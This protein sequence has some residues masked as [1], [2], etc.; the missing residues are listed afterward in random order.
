MVH[1]LYFHVPFCHRICPYCGFYK[2]QPGATSFRAFLDGVILEL[3]AAAKRNPI[4]ARTIYFGGGTPSIF[5]AD[6]WK[7]FAARLADTI[8]LAHVTE[9]TL[10]ANPRT[11]DE[12]KVHAWRETGVTRISLGVQSFHPKI[13]SVL[14]RDHSPDEAAQ[15]V[16]DLRQAA[17]PVVNIDL[18]FAIPGQNLE[19]W[20][21]TLQ[22]AIELQP[23][24]VSAYNLTYEE[25][26]EFLSRF[27][28][29]EWG[30][31]ADRDA[32]F[33]LLA[34][35][36]LGDAGF[37]H[38][39]VSNYAR[40]GFRSLH[41]QAYWAGAEYLGLGPS[42]VSTIGNERRKNLADTDG[43]LKMVAGLGHA[44]HEIEALDAGQQALER[45]ALGLRTEGGIDLAR[46]SA[47]GAGRLVEEGL[48]SREGNRLCL[49]LEG[50]MVA[51]EI[52][53]FL[54]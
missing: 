39:E 50:M 6:L 28:S 48:A 38:Y 46:V 49:T 37:A 12:A 30:Q 14:G 31:D 54:S 33:F 45:L 21:E 9:W 26:T 29:G 17:M 8:D 23:D 51:D 1:H 25:D 35:R 16:R 2:H 34:D 42:A 43:Y 52:A 19:I 40:P 20:G 3:A 10:E 7:T 32:D 36:L 27:E 4:Q 53:A 41:N 11:F 24:H 15:S 22:R 18:M 13:L 5:P 47:E 44:W